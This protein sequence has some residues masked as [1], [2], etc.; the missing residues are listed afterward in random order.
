MLTATSAQAQTIA[1]I[2]RGWYD[3]VGSHTTTNEN[4]IVGITDAGTVHRNW[5]VFAIPSGTYTSA[6]I[7]FQ[8]KP[9]APSGFGLAGQYQ[10]TDPTETYEMFDVNTS[11]ASLIGGTG[12]VAA[13][14]DFGTGTSYGSRVFSAADNNTT[15]IFTLNASALADINS[16]AGGNF[17]IGGVLQ[18]ATANGQTLFSFSATTGELSSSS[19]VLSAASVVPEPGTL[20][21]LGLGM[22]PMVGILVRR[23][24]S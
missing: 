22:L 23:R 8:L 19:L 7:A 20:A 6:T 15:V 17:A 18:T 5:F 16:A 4:V 21:L 2:D 9:F 10:S 24:H 12:G 13:Y 11:T 14:N 3:S 1:P